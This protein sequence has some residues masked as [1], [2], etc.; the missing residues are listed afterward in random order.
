MGKPE[1]FDVSD[2][3]GGGECEEALRTLYIYLD[4]ELTLERRT[5]IKQHLS[6]CAPCL[7]AFDFETELKSLV[8]RSCRDQVPESL[9]HRIADALAQASDPAEGPYR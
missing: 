9:R 1:Q 8:A 2:L 5:A 6:E 3:M 4:G 7:Q